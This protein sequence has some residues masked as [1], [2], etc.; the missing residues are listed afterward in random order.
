MIISQLKDLRGQ[1]FRLLSPIEYI[2]NK[3]WVCQCEC[4][5]VIIRTRRALL[6]GNTRSC[7]CLR[8]AYKDKAPTTGLK[9]LLDDY[10]AHGKEFSLTDEE[11]YTLTF[12]DCFYCGAEPLQELKTKSGAAGKSSRVAFLYNG[13]DRVDNSKGYIQGNCVTACGYCNIAKNRNSLPDLLAWLGNLTS[14][15]KSRS[16]TLTTP[17]F[18]SRICQYNSKYKLS[19]RGKSW[20]LTEVQALELFSASCYYCG[21]F[22]SYGPKDKKFL[23]CGIDRVD[24]EG[25]YFPSNVVPCCK[26]CNGAKHKSKQEDFYKWLNTIKVNSPKIKNLFQ[27]IL[28]SSSEN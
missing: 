20:G 19:Q 4:G 3:G 7:G 28:S 21:G 9:I 2:P 6:R 10:R 13:I 26:I 15:E 27:R 5:N 22:S 16:V 12:S 25:D 18:K 17:Q 23:A 1:K 8:K 11:F 14:E 24:N